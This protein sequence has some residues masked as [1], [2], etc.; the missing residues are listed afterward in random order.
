[1]NFGWIDKS[2]FPVLANY[3]HPTPEH[4]KFR[5]EWG[6]RVAGT[7]WQVGAWVWEN[8]A[9]WPTFRRVPLPT[10]EDAPPWE[11]SWGHRLGEWIG[12]RRWS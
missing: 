3:G 11:P 7:Q 12:R 1:M 6:G 4:G 8:G 2:G 9:I 10:I 5:I